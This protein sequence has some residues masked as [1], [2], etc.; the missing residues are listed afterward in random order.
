MRNV[1]LKTP[2][3]VLT[4]FVTTAGLGFA[5]QTPSRIPRQQRPRLFHRAMR[6]R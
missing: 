3:F 5:G 6:V 4:L 1:N 2:L